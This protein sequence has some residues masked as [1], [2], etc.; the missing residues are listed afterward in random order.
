MTATSI[1]SAAKRQRPCRRPLAAVATVVPAALL[2]LTF[3][4]T[5]ALASGAGTVTNFPMSGYTNPYG[6]TAGPDGNL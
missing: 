3:Y 1:A 5:T 2:L 4:P 6:I